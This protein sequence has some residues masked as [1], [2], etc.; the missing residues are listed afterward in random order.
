MAPGPGKHIRLDLACE[1]SATGY[2]LGHAKDVLRGWQVPR[3]VAG[4][5]LVIVDELITN[6]V[7]HTGDAT[8]PFDPERGRLKVH[9]CALELS[10]MNGSLLISVHDESTRLPAL[11][12]DSLDAEC[13]RG[14]QLVAGLSEGNWGHALLASRDGKPVWARLRL[15]DLARRDSPS[16]PASQGHP[17][18][19]NRRLGPPRPAADGR[20]VVIV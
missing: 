15:A 8:E 19:G 18:Q 5:A 6:A 3:D 13:G 1:P 9:G 12:D 10:V 14:L 7:R 16:T 11:R 17:H 20:A 2:A 4:D